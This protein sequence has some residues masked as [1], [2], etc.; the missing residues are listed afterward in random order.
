MDKNLWVIFT[1]LTVMAICAVWAAP[2]GMQTTQVKEKPPMYSYIAVWNIP[3]DQWK[4]REKQ[5]RRAS[6][7]ARRKVRR[8]I[9]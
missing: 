8:L 9:P 7:P 4:A 1:G 3:R 5:C 6:N 2:A